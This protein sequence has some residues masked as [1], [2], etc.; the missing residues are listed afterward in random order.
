MIRTIE[1]QKNGRLIVDSVNT[2]P[3]LHLHPASIFVASHAKW[4]RGGRR[5]DGVISMVFSIHRMGNR[6]IIRG[7]STLG[8]LAG[9]GDGDG[10]IFAWL[11]ACLRSIAPLIWVSIRLRAGLNSPARPTDGWILVDDWLFHDSDSILRGGRSISGGGVGSEAFSAHIL[12]SM[13]PNHEIPVLSLDGK[14]SNVTPDRRIIITECE[15]FQIII[16]SR[17]PRLRSMSQQ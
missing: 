2:P 1:P 7:Q 12:E 16:S 11:L 9:V 6:G 10:R 4:R 15:Q 3:S 13:I 8:G 5:H 14:A 17:I